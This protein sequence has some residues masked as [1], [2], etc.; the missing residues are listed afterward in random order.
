MIQAESVEAGGY[1][2]PLDRAYDPVTKLWVQLVEGG[3][4][5]VGLDALELEVAGTLAQLELAPPGSEILRGEPFGSLEAAKFVGPLLAPVSGTV[6]AHNEAVLADPGLAEQDPL[7]AGWL[8]ELVPSRLA[9]ELPELLQGDAA[10]APWLGA[11][12]RKYR[13]EGSLAE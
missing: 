1:A 13:L 4:A 6:V 10:V 8:V 11:R 9:D 12:V 5:R 2:L 3:R 7:G